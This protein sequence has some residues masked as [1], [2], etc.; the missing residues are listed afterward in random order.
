MRP[1]PQ[2]FRKLVGAR[3]YAPPLQPTEYAL[4]NVTLPVF[5]AI[6]HPDSTR[7]WAML[8]MNMMAYVYRIPIP[9]KQL[10]TTFIWI[11]ILKT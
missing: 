8:L 6:E 9:I 11:Y 7:A 1:L 2:N 10:F 4:D 5:L 3:T